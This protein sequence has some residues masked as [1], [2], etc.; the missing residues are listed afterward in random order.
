M[1]YQ[2]AKL[3]AGEESDIR[4][5]KDGPMP[6]EGGMPEEVL[7][8]VKKTGV[9]RNSEVSNNFASMKRVPT[10][11]ADFKKIYPKL[12]E[13][14]ISQ[15]LKPDPWETITALN[16]LACP[17]PLPVDM[18]QST[19]KKGGIR[20]TNMDA[21]ATAQERLK[22]NAV[23]SYADQLLD[24]HAM[25]IVGQRKSKKNGQCEFIIRNSYGKDCGASIEEIPKYM[26]KTCDGQGNFIISAPI[27][28]E[29]I[30]NIYMISPLQKSHGAT[31][32]SGRQSESGRR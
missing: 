29:N 17:H 12:S 18:L 21:I 30:Q 23:V 13:K 27:L 5:F 15:A 26:I 16:Q 7:D 19:T 4:N 20:G 8:V 25:T 2:H 1:A 11:L 22:V 24:G 28:L 3:K 9:C 10:T 32:K 6:M 14:Q 31:G